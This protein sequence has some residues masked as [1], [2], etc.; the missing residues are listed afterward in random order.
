MTATCDLGPR[1][2][3]PLAVGWLVGA[4]HLAAKLRLVLHQVV[5]RTTGSRTIGHFFLRLDVDRVHMCSRE[6]SGPRR[7]RWSSVFTDANFE[8]RRDT[9][10]NRAED[11]MIRGAVVM[12]ALPEGAL[13]AAVGVQ[14]DQQ[15]VRG[16]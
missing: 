6:V 10:S 15:I 14:Q 1:R 7:N 11:G 12:L 9:L 16:A 8:D 13:V 5:G 3:T 4:A 2:Q